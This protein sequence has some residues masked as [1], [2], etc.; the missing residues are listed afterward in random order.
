MLDEERELADYITLQYSTGRFG[1]SKE[2]LHLADMIEIKISQGAKPGMGGKLPG[3]KVTAQIAAVRQ[4]PA[5][6]MAQS[7]AVHQDI[8]SPA[9]LSAKILELRT[10]TGG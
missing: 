8:T 5:G 6:K 10:L 1:I 3:V 9:D 4:I 7:P 2:R